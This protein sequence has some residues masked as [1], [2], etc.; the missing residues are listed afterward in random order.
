M[1]PTSKDAEDR[2]QSD[3]REASPDR[4]TDAVRAA[5]GDRR[6]V[7]SRGLGEAMVD[8]LEDILHWERA[9]ERS[10]QVAPRASSPDLTH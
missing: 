1:K 2:R 9:S 3:R 7:E 5:L 4:R 10:L 8:A 6:V